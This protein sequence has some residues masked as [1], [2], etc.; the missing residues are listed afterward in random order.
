MKNFVKMNNKTG[1]FFIVS[2][3]IGNL[4]DITVRALEILEEVDVIACEDTRVTSKLLRR[5][6]INKRLISYF[7]HNEL[8]RGPELIKLLKQ[9]KS[10]ALVTD[11]GTPGICDPGYR[12]IRLVLENNL[13]MTVI[14]GPSAL[15]A[16]LVLSGKSPDR[17]IFEG[18]LPRKKSK[19]RK[20]LKE[21]EDEKRTIIFYESPHRI[22]KS[23]NDIRSVFS[24]RE[25]CCLRELTK[26]FEEV[27]KDSASGLIEVFEKKKPKGEFIL[28]L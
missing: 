25:I 21:L 15:T 13:P 18:Y 27:I 14:P 9:G 19:R 12:I 6:N 24:D 20:R 17:F 2:T 11:A 28:I 10:I 5:Y 3:P 16:A 4:K 8:R 22:I 7:E 26:S 23:L 1:T